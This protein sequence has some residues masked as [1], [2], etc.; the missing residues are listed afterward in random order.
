MSLPSMKTFGIASNFPGII[1]VNF[2]SLLESYDMDKTINFIAEATH[3][4][5]NL[6]ALLTASAASSLLKSVHNGHTFYH[7]Q[8]TSIVL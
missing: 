6:K 4:S 7:R 5:L 3:C 1:Q 2:M 8:F